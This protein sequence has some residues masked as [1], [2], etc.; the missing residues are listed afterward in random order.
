MLDNDEREWLAQWEWLCELEAGWRRSDRLA[1]A[2]NT[3]LVLGF[4]LGPTF[5]DLP[6]WA[7]WV[8]LACALFAGWQTGTM[9]RHVRT[10]REHFDQMAYFGHPFADYLRRKEDAA[11]NGHRRT[12]FL[13][14]KAPH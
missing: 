14:P 1:L 11:G 3:V 8:C 9:L 7:A 5:L 13:P 2:T 10:R 4:C 12:T 6:T